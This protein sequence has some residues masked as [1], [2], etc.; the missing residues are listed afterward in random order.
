MDLVKN[1]SNGRDADPGKIARMLFSSPDPTQEYSFEEL[2]P[3]TDQFNALTAT[4][5]EVVM[6]CTRFLTT[7][8]KQE[9]RDQ[10]AGTQN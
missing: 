2:P 7:A 6:D 10:L 9:I 5:L 8:T 4:E 3:N 1:I